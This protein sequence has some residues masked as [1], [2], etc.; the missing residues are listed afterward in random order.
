MSVTNVYYQEKQYGMKY[1]TKIID[2]DFYDVRIFFWVRVPA[3]F[4]G[5]PPRI[6]FE[7]LPANINMLDL[8]GNHDM[9]DYYLRY[10]AGMDKI[11]KGIN[12]NNCV[13]DISDA[14]LRYLSGNDSI[15]N[16]IVSNNNITNN[17]LIYLS[18]FESVT[19][20]CY[21]ITMDGMKYLSGVPLPQY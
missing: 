9:S 14:A 7:N 15:K 16:I 6:L 11:I 3:P 13:F 17:G 1:V 5:D 18:A 20:M 2:S 12:L 8:S 19:L 21:K 10:L 4:G